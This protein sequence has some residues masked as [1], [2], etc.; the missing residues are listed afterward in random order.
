MTT[1]LPLQ[2]FLLCRSLDVHEF[3]GRL[4]DA[5]YPAEVAPQ[6]GRRF[7]HPSVLHALRT[8]DVTL[9]FI[10]PGGSVRVTPELEST[11]YHVNLALSGSA[12]AVAGREEVLVQ[13]GFAAVHTAGERHQLR[14]QADSGLIGLKLSRG[15][16]ERELSALLGHPA[17]GPV[18]F[19]PAFDLRGPAGRSWLAMV[20]FLLDELDRPG[21]FDTPAVRDSYL[22]SLVTGLLSSQPHN[23][24][25]ALRSGG[26]P[27]RPRT[28]RRAQEFI[29]DHFAEPLTV[30]DV[31]RATGS[32]VRRLQE[33]FSAHLDVSPMGYL[34]DVRLDVTRARLTA[35]GISVTEAA[36]QCGFT[37]LGRF[38]AAYR[39]RFG[40]L[41]S[42]T[43]AD[44]PPA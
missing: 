41:P 22:R 39:A 34:R 15:L 43:G 8:E 27:L 20:Q 16:V 33:S 38:S 25:E 14:T 2:R 37:H 9:G 42:A 7:T 17:A 23:W 5:Y 30:T 36:Q 3:T 21:V 13:P 10:R 24:S 19:S 29:K 28:V 40:E 6:L 11:S 1:A 4:N 12:V 44:A 32:S 18:R 31:A 26:A 35:G